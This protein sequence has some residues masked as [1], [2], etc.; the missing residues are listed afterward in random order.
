MEK[1]CNNKIDHS[2]KTNN[3]NKILIIAT[4]VVTLI[5]SNNNTNNNNNKSIDDNQIIW[6]IKC[7]L[8]LCLRVFKLSAFF[9]EVYS[10]PQNS[11]PEFF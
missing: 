5:Y 1:N 9:S 3:N 2:N 10:E 6:L 8:S 4:T 7:F 11:K